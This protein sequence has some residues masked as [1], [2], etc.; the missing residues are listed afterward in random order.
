VG[1]SGQVVP[2]TGYTWHRDPDGGACFPSVGGGWIYV[3]NSERA[4]GSGGASMLSFDAGGSIVEARSI[5]SGTSRNCAGGPTPWGTWLSCEETATGQVWECD[6]TGLTPAVARPL[7]GRFNHEA[8]A[9]DPVNHAVYLT[10]DEPDG[11]LYRFVPDVWGNLGA[12]RL[13][14]LTEAA[15]MLG[16]A[17]VPDPDGSP[18]PTR[19]QVPNTKRFNGGEGAWWGANTL[20]FTTKGDHRVWMLEPTTPALV[21]LYD[22]N[23]STAPHLSGV[24]NITMSPGG[25]LFVAE[26]GGDMQILAVLDNRAFPVLQVTGVTGSEVTGPAFSPDGTRLYFSSQRNPGTTYEVTGPFRSSSN[27]PI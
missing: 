18:V 7:L 10:E 12:G 1:T 20:R 9:A 26:D 17:P 15:G 24:D 22:R 4:S 27:Q 2:G 6:P 19:N 14:V 8:A 13:D 11:A 3:S 21:L 25:D 23:T 16:W 5:L